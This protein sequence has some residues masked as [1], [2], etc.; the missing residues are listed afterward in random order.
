M[1]KVLIPL[2]FNSHQINVVLLGPYQVLTSVTELE[3]GFPLGKSFRLRIKL[4]VRPHIYTHRPQGS[5]YYTFITALSL[6]SS[7][8]S[9]NVHS[10]I[11]KLLTLL[12][13]KAFHVLNMLAGLIQVLNWEELFVEMHTVSY[14]LKLI[15]F[16]SLFICL[17]I[18]YYSINF[19]LK[20][21]IAKHGPSHVRQG[22]WLK[23]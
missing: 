8:A 1:R 13:Y 16:L 3:A 19:W 5:C 17:F 22:T 14:L 12:A 21:Y 7:R 15:I 9:Q 10:C 20:I 23:M 4:S 6:S 18:I 2:Q 11:F